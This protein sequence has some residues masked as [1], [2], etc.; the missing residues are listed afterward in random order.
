M[1][2]IRKLRYPDGDF[3]IADLEVA[4]PMI[5]SSEVRVSLAEAISNRSVSFIGNGEGVPMTY[6]KVQ[7]KQW[8]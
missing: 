3:T 8:P 7:V 4:N 1:L 5:P 2:L 6:H